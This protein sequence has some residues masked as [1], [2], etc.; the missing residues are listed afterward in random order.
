[1]PPDEILRSLTDVG[2]RKHPTVSQTKHIRDSMSILPFVVA[3]GN[4]AIFRKRLLDRAYVD[5]VGAML[6]VVVDVDRGITNS[7]NAACGWCKCGV[8]VV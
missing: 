3:A 7:V 5:N 8:N 4:S 1:M 2:R 6:G